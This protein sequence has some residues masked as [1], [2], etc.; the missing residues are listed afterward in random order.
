MGKL[1][2]IFLE[3]REN[4]SITK[5]QK[6]NFFCTSVCTNYLYNYADF[7]HLAYI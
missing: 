2:K 1:M 4:P 5:P 3:N 6:S 7:T